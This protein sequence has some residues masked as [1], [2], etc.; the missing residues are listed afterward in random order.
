MISEKL[1]NNIEIYYLMNFS[2][3]DPYDEELLYAYKSFI[4]NVII[5]LGEDW[6]I[7]SGL[8]SQEIET[9]QEK[10]SPE[11]E[12]GRIAKG[13][14]NIFNEFLWCFLKGKMGR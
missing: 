8:L 5:E 6:R 1:E 13:D 3:L 14:F 4:E 12:N 11:S 9:S 7:E 2:I 10:A